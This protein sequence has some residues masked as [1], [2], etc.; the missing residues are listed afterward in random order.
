M[1]N[2][3]MVPLRRIDRGWLMFVTSITVGLVSLV[4]LIFWGY[5]FEI[6]TV[7]SDLTPAIKAKLVALNVKPRAVE[8]TSE[9]AIRVRNA[10][11]QED[12]STADKIAAAVL[13]SSHIENWRFYPY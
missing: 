3:R 4:G 13:A 11:K 9:M 10:I 1:K 2:T 8:L 12:Y 7:R 6:N 5:R